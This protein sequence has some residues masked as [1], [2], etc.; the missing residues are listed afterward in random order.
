MKKSIVITFVTLVLAFV[1]CTKPL[2]YTADNQLLEENPCLVGEIQMEMK[3]PLGFKIISQSY[4]DSIAAIRALENPFDMKLLRIFADTILHANIS[5]SD[6]RHIPYEK[7]ENDLDFYKTTYNANG[8]WD[9][10]TIERYHS[11]NYPKIVL[12]EMQNSSKT[13][14]RGLFYNDT[15]AQFCLDYYFPTAFYADFMPFVQASIASIQPNYEI[16]IQLEW[17]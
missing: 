2:P 9:Q 3:L 13:L 7:T 11:E 8:F 1:S 16:Q 14:V 10:V 17:K 4:T 15:K 6:M 5:L 12:L